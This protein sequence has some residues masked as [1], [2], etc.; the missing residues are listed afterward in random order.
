MDGIGRHLAVGGGTHDPVGGDI[1]HPA[2]DPRGGAL[3]EGVQL[4]VGV[5]PLVDVGDVFDH[6]VALDDQRVIER[7]DIHQRMAGAD[8]PADRVDLQGDHLPGHRGGDGEPGAGVEQRQELLLDVG[9]PLLHLELAADRLLAV[10]VLLVGDAQLELGDLLPQLRLGAEQGG[11]FA[12]V[13]G[14]AP[15][16]GEDA[17][18]VDVLLGKEHQLGVELLLQGADDLRFGL[19]PAVNAPVLLLDLVDLLAEQAGA[20]AQGLAAGVEHLLRRGQQVLVVV[21]RDAAVIGRPVD[22]GGEVDLGVEAGLLEAGDGHL[23]EHLVAGG[24]DPRTVEHQQRLAG[25]DPIAV[26]HQ[27]GLDDPPFKV[28]DGLPF[29]IDAHLAGGDHRPGD[30]RKGDP[31]PADAE[32]DQDD[33]Q[34][35][36]D[37]PP[38]AR[39][40]DGQLG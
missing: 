37:N 33:Q 13:L 19:E 36:G 9:D 24:D 20:V 8:H 38:A 31:G 3:L 16:Q 23:Q 11:L 30:F 5:L 12:A 29:G 22:A 28:L 1:D 2:G 17:D 39:V 25:L 34:A 18:L 7:D 27:D 15:P 32:E 14:D 21:D 6:H 4:D 40:A 35:D 10:L 26:A